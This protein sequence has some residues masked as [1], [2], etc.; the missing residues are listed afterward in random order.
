M[1]DEYITIEIVL[2]HKTERFSV[3]RTEDL[4]TVLREQA[5]LGWPIGN[6]HNK[7][8][9]KRCKY[10]AFPILLNGNVMNANFI[11][12]R[13]ANQSEIETID[14][15]IETDLMKQLTAAFLKS[16]S[17]R[18]GYCVQGMEVAIYTLLQRDTLPTL[19]DIRR[20][21]SG[22]LCECAG[23]E[24]I[25]KSVNALYKITCN[26]PNMASNAMN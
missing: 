21:S 15:L 1:L 24:K 10:R 3:T 18:Y 11:F 26:L 25:E 20:V 17:N 23:R 4:A 14:S 2:N 16:N 7:E 22:N 19:E 5:G 12:A 6:E 9:C 13:D 8:K